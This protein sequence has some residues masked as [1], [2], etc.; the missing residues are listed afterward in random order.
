MIE[1][2]NPTLSRNKILSEST[3]GSFNVKEEVLP[4]GKV[5]F[6]LASE[7]LDVYTDLTLS[8]IKYGW[9]ISVHIAS[10]SSEFV[11]NLYVKLG[12]SGRKNKSETDPLCY[13]LCEDFYY[14]LEDVYTWLSTL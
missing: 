6:S 13:S 3:Y 4:S 12:S 9:E 8:A 10:A 5:R 11:D 14:A 2:I 1:Y 7:K